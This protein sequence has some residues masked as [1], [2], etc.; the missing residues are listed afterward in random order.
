MLSNAIAKSNVRAKVF[1]ETYG[2]GYWISKETR[3]KFVEIYAAPCKEFVTLVRML[4]RYADFTLHET[5]IFMVNVCGKRSSWSDSGRINY[6]CYQP[7]KCQT[8]INFIRNNRNSK[9]AV[10]VSIDEY[11]SHG[12]E[13]DYKI[14]QYQE[15]EWYGCRGKVLTLNI[16]TPSG[17]HKATIQSHF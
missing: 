7:N 15:S 17:K 1:S 4:E 5:D 3:F 6:L 8:I 11:F 13:T 2:D 14:A 9:D 10:M 16:S 12:D